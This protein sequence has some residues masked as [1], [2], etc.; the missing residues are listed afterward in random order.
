VTAGVFGSAAAEENETLHI[1]TAGSRPI[2]I[3]RLIFSAFRASGIAAS[4]EVTETLRGIQAANSGEIAG[5][6]S[7]TPNLESEYPNLFRVNQKLDD[8]R[9]AVFTRGETILSWEELSGRR[10]ALLAD[11]L[12][13]DRNLPDDAERVA[14]K[15]DLAALDALAA[16]EV[17]AAVISI[18]ERETFQI[19]EGVSL[20]AV[21][22]TVGEYLYMNN[23]Y[24]HTALAVAKELT[25][26]GAD[27]RTE[28]IVG[29]DPLNPTFAKV[30]LH[31]T[32]FAQ[33]NLREVR[34]TE[35]MRKPFVND[36][37]VEWQMLEMQVRRL[38]ELDRADHFDQLI[39]WR[40]LTTNLSA[41][42]VS[43]DD[44]YE[45]IR[46]RYYLL[47][48]GTPV[49]VYGV[50]EEAWAEVERS[51]PAFTG[52]FD[53][54]PAAETVAGALRLFPETKTIFVVNDFT[55]EGTHYREATERQ[56]ASLSEQIS[57]LYN[58]DA[59]RNALQEEIQSLPEN[60]LV[61]VGSYFRDA[62]GQYFTLGEMGHFFAEHCAA[63]VFSPHTAVLAYNAIGGKC[64]DYALYGQ[65]AAAWLTGLLETGESVAP[66]KDGYPRWVFDYELLRAWDI[67]ERSLPEGSDVINKPSVS[68][69]VIGIPIAL[70]LI[71]L[72]ALLFWTQRR[73]RREAAE[74]RIVKNR[75]ESIIGVAPVAYL[76]CVDNLVREINESMI[77]ETGLNIGDDIT[78]VFFEQEGEEPLIDRV[79]KDGFLHS[80]LV[81]YRTFGGEIH[82][83]IVNMVVV[84]YDGQEGF[85]IWSVDNEEEERKKDEIK[86]ARENLQ[87]ILDFLPE[88]IR[89]VDLASN[90]IAYLNY[91]AIELLGYN[92]FEPFIGLP[93]LLPMPAS[94]PD[95]TDSERALEAIDHT[96]TI[97]MM[98][99]VCL[100]RNGTPFNIQM[101]ACPIDYQGRRSSLCVLKDMTADK[102]AEQ[103]LLNTIEREKEA[104]QSKSAFLSNMSHEIRTPMNAI[105]GLTELELRR[106][107]PEGTRTVYKK[108][109]TSAKNLLQ[110]I[111]D[112]LDL[113]KIEAEKLEILQEDFRLE[114]VLNSAMLVASPRLEGKRVEMLLDV[115]PELPK[116]LIGD[117]TRL[118]QI[119]KNFLDNSAKYTET[120]SVILR[121]AP[122]VSRSD[123]E[124]VMIVFEIR[125]TGIGMSE[126]DLNRVFRPYEQTQNAAQ[127]HYT[128]TGLGMSIAKNLCE[129]MKGTLTAFSA[130]GAGTSIR[131]D[132]PFR[133]AAE[134]G[135]ILSGEKGLAGIRVLAADDDELSRKIIATLLESGGAECV[136]AD[137]GEAAVRQIVADRNKGKAFDIIL[138]DYLMGG[139]NGLES[140][141]KIHMCLSVV[142]PILLVTSFQRML[143]QNE[144]EKNGV[145]GVMEKPLIPS[146]F[147]KRL[148]VALR[149]EEQGDTAADIKAYAGFRDARVLVC[150]DNMINQEVA[151]GILNQ[152]GVTAVVA[153]NGKLGIEAYRA[154]GP[155]DVI[156]MDLQMPVMDGFEA[157]R[158]LR[159]E[160]ASL[161][162]ISLSA[163]AM[164]E[165]TEKCR[166][167][168]MNDTINKP[169]EIDQFYQTLRKWIPEEKRLMG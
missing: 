129:L 43:G 14:L 168:G 52:V 125:D 111:N 148:R 1:A 130:P 5:V 88:P 27:G 149:L 20:S 109:S 60:S 69:V 140:A 77:L 120:G 22:E 163:D 37:T 80:A 102:E 13:A 158:A 117:E 152:F 146:Q 103:A 105:I 46:D 45:F 83:S 38:N 50:G 153:D 113:S 85:V 81:S 133:R 134:E 141:R 24:E 154:K 159:A 147:I 123:G 76:L 128:G 7:A 10:V 68:P 30:V 95:G 144:L 143:L 131:L 62:D 18:R 87:T 63:P 67:G 167:A 91:A 90:T 150:E 104:N 59:G 156:L 99:L 3:D 58:A 114:D 122:D 169:V 135:S 124:T 6:V 49:F 55:A 98:E 101:T 2:Y 8:V 29:G 106:E 64:L 89:I 155:F 142:P 15:T 100:R 161:P 40:C 157:A 36:D 35:E 92:L 32:S 16:G 48:P 47:F 26:M 41:V 119:L 56:L 54:F 116:T 139:M 112:I 93:A 39:R 72:T 75:L 53:P 127:K 78:G 34:F 164:T 74:E 71:A 33:D 65:A 25:R 107:Q 160:G 110:I 28:R 23:A 115:S 11:R 151:V 42:V 17:D 66:P 19:P 132:I 51:S 44:A 79:R 118:W 21:L 31:I 12:Y 108:I 94:Q 61:L 165:V 57:V 162:I 84:D 70:V 137:S 9:I 4:L 121:A 86:A 138:L 97:I 96:E 82:R 126:E 136:L 73:R 145:D 166:E